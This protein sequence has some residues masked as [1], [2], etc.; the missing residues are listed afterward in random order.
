MT[1]RILPPLLL[2]VGSVLSLSACGFQP[3]YSAQAVN[4]AQAGD[5][6]INEIEGRM[7]HELR[8]ALVLGLQPGLPGVTEP[9]SLTI[10]LDENLRRLA[11]QPD[12]AA[13]RSDARGRAIY[14]FRV[15]ERVVKGTVLGEASF[16]VPLEP[17]ADIAGQTAARARAARVL[18]DRII[19]DLQVQLTRPQG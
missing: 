11:F 4:G 1:Q 8:K 15:G 7:G 17:Y 19:A 13:S 9:A 3:V 16:N 5:I 6:A 18:A 2:L 14:E 12:G 10:T